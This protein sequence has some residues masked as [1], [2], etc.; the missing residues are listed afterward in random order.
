MFGTVLT[1]ASAG[2]Y[3]GT[4]ALASHVDNA[5]TQDDLLGDG[6]GQHREH[7]TGPLD[8]L[9]AGSDFRHS[10]K[11]SKE[12]PRSDTIMWLHIPRTLD[13]AYL[14]SIPR[15]LEVDIPAFAPSDFE[16]STEKINAA[17][18]HGA[19][20]Y[21]DVA[22]GMTLLKKTLKQVTG[23]NFQMAA[24]VNWDGFK[25][26]T[27]QLGGVTLC[28]EEGFTSTQPGVSNKTLTF[29][30]GCHHYDAE[31]ALNLVRQR[32]NY[33]DSDYGRQRMQQQFIKQILKQ[34]TQRGVLTS[35]SKMNAV[36]EAAGKA[37]T[38]DLNGYGIVDLALALHQV[39]PS[40]LV[41]LQIA[42]ETLPDG[43][44][45]LQPVDDALFKA[46]RTDKVDDF[47]LTHPEL[48]SK[49]AGSGR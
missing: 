49:G 45:T 46:L 40:K 30:A 26:I 18:A 16:G 19:K 20:D 7:V 12:K 36:L 11:E 41:T 31:M 39:T 43:N 1:I 44:E 15:D 4:A 37:L 38:V 2:T 21:Q 34:A 27:E 35:P 13:S 25:A 10:W 8:V 48:V 5:V 42:H 47:L 28:L 14:L 33:S 22:G 32:Y 6:D 29:Q 9:L 17:F 23:E 3:A 24:L